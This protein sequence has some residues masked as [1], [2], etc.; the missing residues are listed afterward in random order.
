MSLISGLCDQTID[1]IYSISIDGAND[2]TRTEVYK[3][4]PCRWNEK[5]NLITTA[6]AEIRQSRVE[7]WLL[8][9]YTIDEGY[10]FVKD[11]DTYKV[12]GRDNKY[13]LNGIK[14]HVKVYLV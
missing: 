11:G 8:P 13:D 10:E 9:E 2:K 12:I 3:D 7:A 5:V 4:V 1:Y 6:D 14:D